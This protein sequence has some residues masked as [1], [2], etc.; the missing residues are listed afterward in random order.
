MAAGRYTLTTSSSSTLFL[1]LYE[2]T[3]RLSGEGEKDRSERATAVVSLEPA[4]MFPGE[5]EDKGH[6][7]GVVGE[8]Q[9][10]YDGWPGSCACALDSMRPRA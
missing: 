9:P 7:K 5:K 6:R 4:L 3:C 10:E 8:G 1:D 2:D